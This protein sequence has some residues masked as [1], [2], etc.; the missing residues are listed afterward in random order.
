MNSDDLL[1][2]KPWSIHSIPHAVPSCKKAPLP[3]SAK[4]GLA[5][6]LVVMALNQFMIHFGADRQSEEKETVYIET[7]TPSGKPMHTQ[8]AIASACL[9]SVI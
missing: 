4:Q 2:R 8:M 9:A 7:W 6:D 1:F 3:A 5:Q